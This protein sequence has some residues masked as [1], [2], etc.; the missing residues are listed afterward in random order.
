[1]AQQIDCG[2]LVLLSYGGTA[3]VPVEVTSSCLCCLRLA[4][5]SV[6]LRDRRALLQTSTTTS[7]SPRVSPVLPQSSLLGNAH[8]PCR[9]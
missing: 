6:N 5:S 8:T 4:K 3:L 9:R 2:I 1:M 7:S